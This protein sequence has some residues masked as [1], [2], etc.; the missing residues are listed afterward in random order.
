[1]NSTARKSS[2]TRID[3]ALDRHLSRRSREEIRFRVGRSS[4]GHVLVASSQKGVVSILVG[5]DPDQLVRNLRREF[6]K[7][8]I[9]HSNQNDR[10]RVA[11][12]LEFIKE[13]K[14]FLDIPLDLRGTAFQQKV[15]QSVREIP[16]GQTTTY[17]DVAR[18]I[19]APKAI[20]AVGRACSANKLAIA[21]PCHRVL[22]SD[23]SLPEGE[24][25]GLRR[26]RILLR[27]E[28]GAA[29][30]KLVEER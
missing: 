15:W 11:R 13:P 29:V 3:E 24:H 18:K 4:L 22:R 23:G 25:W 27:R 30:A 20:R 6:L 21:V 8:Q 9:L 14:A 7:S 17:A 10:E 5:Q 26:R 12:V 19:G 1:M 2:N 16:L 28:S